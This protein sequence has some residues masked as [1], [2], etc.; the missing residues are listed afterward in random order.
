M[1]SGCSGEALPWSTWPVDRGATS[2]YGRSL[3]PPP[4]DT[5]ARIAAAWASRSPVSHE[6]L[7]LGAWLLV[8]LSS[9]LAIH[10]VGEPIRS[11]MR[12]LLILEAAVAVLAGRRYWRTRLPHWLLA[13]F[14]ATC[15]V[16]NGFIWAFTDLGT[17][18]HDVH[19]ASDTAAIGTMFFL[20]VESATP[21]VRASRIASLAGLLSCCGFL[22]VVPALLFGL[23]P[24][25]LGELLPL[26]IHE[27]SAS[28]LALPAWTPFVGLV[29]AVVGLL[30]GNALLVDEVRGACASPSSWCSRSCSAGQQCCC[31]M[32]APCCWPRFPAT[33]AAR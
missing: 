13:S 7:S 21:G 23:G 19:V 24:A 27:Q 31:S 4:G 9:E 1:P 12:P 2:S 25:A 3:R 17:T 33:A 11:A 18:L 20:L 5:P 16:L 14:A 22:L 29:P 28:V 10:G 8:V 6:A 30:A 15:L 26:V 32:A